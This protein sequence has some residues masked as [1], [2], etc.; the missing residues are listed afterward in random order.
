MKFI[1]FDSPVITIPLVSNMIKILKIIIIQGI[2]FIFIFYSY[3][4]W[5]IFS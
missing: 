1:I 5:H 3:V 2:L 4:L